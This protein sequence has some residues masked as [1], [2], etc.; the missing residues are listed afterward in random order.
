M[1]K[2]LVLLTIPFLFSAPEKPTEWKEYLGGPDRNHYSTLKQINVS[3][4]NNL[5]KVWEFHT[6]DTSG[7][8]QCNP[9]IVNG[10]LYGS[11][12]SLEIFALEAATGKQIW[13]FSASKDSKWYSMNRGVTYWEEGQD[14]RI[15]F[16]QGNWLYALDAITGN[17]VLSFGNKGKVS[18]SIGL[19]QS[20]EK[21]FVISTTPGTVFED[22]IIMPLRLSESS[23]AALGFIQAFNIK[24]GK[25]DWVFKTIPSP[26]EFGYSTWGKDNYKNGNV[27][28]ANNWAGMSIDR[29]RGMIFVP[30]GSAAFDFYGGNRKG[31]NLFANCLLALDAHTGKRK[32][33]FQ[34]VHHDVWDRD[35]PAPPNL[36]TINRNGK[37]ID[38]VAQ[39]TKQGYV[40]VFERETGK[41]VF[42]IDEVQVATNGL[43]GEL[44][45]LTQPIPQKPA[46]FARNK[47]TEK[48]INPYAENKDELIS[49]FRKIRKNMFDPPSKEGTIIF[50]GFDGGGEWGGASFDPETG[51]MY[52][53]SSE[54]PNILTM[55]DDTK[56]SDLAK[57]TPGEAVYMKNC[58][59][60]HNPNKEGNLKSG[61]PSLVDLKSKR[62]KGLIVDIISKGKGMMPGF[63]GLSST[64]KQSVV[65][66]LFGSEKLEVGIQ[67]K[68]NQTN[69]IPYRMTGY[70]KF[71]DKN[72]Y[73]AVEPPWGTLSAINLNT[74]DYVWKKPLGED[75]KLTAK[76]IPVTGL[77]NYGGGVVTAGGL[78]IIGATKDET[79]RIFDKKTGE[80]IWQTELP[81]S[82]FATPSTYEVNGIQYIVIACGGNKLG[83]KKG[84]SFVAFAL[85]NGTH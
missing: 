54:M 57:M 31:D 7:Q 85:K 73:P 49:V 65:D 56:S 15:L 35:L 71:L 9:I 25:I 43:K 75:K 74:G 17:P 76:G 36:I 53:N 11:T 3:N 27:G 32:W 40:F 16:T 34:F 60:C 19:G 5:Q 66:Y 28:G 8:M 20:A 38:A 46:P 6:S 24:T 62:E 64:E 69:A 10:M 70:N 47:M 41:P 77:E 55:V 67:S 1:K 52:I 59:S 48:N 68:K 12:A 18:L 51:Y 44:L 23:D 2:L 83:T 39:I 80:I 72:G 79:F 61:Y 33:H 45:S 58:A 82:A 30:T 29:K 14:K 4:V 42:K 63:G 78:F 50:P 21:K 84:D 81:A 22:K 26:G 13:R 37:K